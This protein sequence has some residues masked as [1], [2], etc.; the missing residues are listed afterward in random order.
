MRDG[1]SGMGDGLWRALGR[2]LSRPESDV[3][4]VCGQ[5]GKVDGLKVL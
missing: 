5:T 2:V 3:I 4:L 1:R